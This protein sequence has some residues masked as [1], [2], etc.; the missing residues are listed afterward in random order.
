MPND[1]LHRDSRFIFPSYKRAG[2]FK[3]ATKAHARIITCGYWAKPPLSASLVSAYVRCHQIGLAERVVHHVLSWCRNLLTLNIFLRDLLSAGQCGV[4]RKLFDKMPERDVVTW[5]SMIGGLTRNGR[6]HDALASFRDMLALDVEPDGFTFASV[7]TSCARVGF[8]SHALW[9]HGLM[10]EKKIEPH[11]IL[12]AALIDMYARCGKIQVAREIFDSIQRGDVSV[13]NS[14]INGLAIHGHARDAITVFSDMEREKV[15]P[16]SITFVGILTA[17]SRCGLV[18]E[19]RMYFDSMRSRYSIQPEIQHY[20]A[21]VD[22]LARAGS[23]D[24]AYA[25]IKEMPTKPD[26]AIWRT[27]LSSCRVFKRSRLGEVAIANIPRRK[28]GDYVL[29]SNTY[30]SLTRWDSAA[31]TRNLMTRKGV[32][33]NCGKSW[34]ELA[35]EIHQFRSGDRSHRETEA[36]YEALDELIKRTKM[37]GFVPS[38]ELVLMDV[39]DEEKEENLNFHSEKLAVAYGVLKSSPGSEIVVLKNLRICYDCHCWI[40]LVSRILIRTIVVRD[41]LRFHQFEGGL[42][43]CDDYW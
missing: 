10:I 35:G 16:D 22:L 37:A 20:G 2:D 11:F 5:N 34:I 19:G 40:K 4:A 23:V 26:A 33:K 30:C 12:N 21:M 36:L 38:M 15:S 28:S 7:F 43:S 25:M 39:A 32:G 29:L 41:R 1:W 9:A 6:F 18:E 13:W 24:E 42:C 14:M 8:L 3:T 31:K 17:C 27:L